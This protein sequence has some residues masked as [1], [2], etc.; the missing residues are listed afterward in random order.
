[1]CTLRHLLH[2]LSDKLDVLALMMG[3]TG[4]IATYA[5]NT[6]DTLNYTRS[7]GIIIPGFSILGVILGTDSGKVIATFFGYFALTTFDL[8]S[9]QGTTGYTRGGLMLCEGAVLLVVLSNTIRGRSLDKIVA[10]P[11]Y[12][13]LAQFIVGCTLVPNNY[14]LHFLI[15][16]TVVAA[17]NF[18][19]EDYTR[20]AYLLLVLD[21]VVGNFLLVSGI[22][23]T[24]IINFASGVVF[25][26]HYLKG[27][28]KQA[29]S[30]KFGN[31]MNAPIETVTETVKEVA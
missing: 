2:G 9:T 25:A 22:S 14:S 30:I 5:F 3:I 29:P 19:D 31:D 10:Y 18:D 13:A 7:Y 6:S 21:A 8:G 26:Y 1:V 15:A 17:E 23:N 4:T 16:L 20:V 24:T 27:G 28:A 12:V 11:S